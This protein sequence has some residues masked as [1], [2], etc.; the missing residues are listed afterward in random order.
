MNATVCMNV[1]GLPAK[2]GDFIN[3]MMPLVDTTKFVAGDYGI[4]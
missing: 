1:E 2:E 4:G 3:Q